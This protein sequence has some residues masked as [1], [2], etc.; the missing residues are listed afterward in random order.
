MARFST[1]RE[2]FFF[3]THPRFWFR[4][5]LRIEEMLEDPLAQ[6]HVWYDQ[7]ER[8]SLLEFPNGMCLST[9]GEDGYPQGRMV[10]MKE[11]DSEGVI[12][13]TNSNSQKGKALELT[14][15]A[16]VTFYW[17]AFQRQ[18]RF[19]GDVELLESSSSDAY[20]ASR[21]RRSQLGAWASAQSEPIES[22]EV[23]EKRVA[24][25]ETEYVHKPIPRPPYW[26]GYRLTPRMVEFWQLGLNRL[27]DRIRYVRTHDG[28]WKKER[29]SP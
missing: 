2:V 19:E 10:L 6:F 24:E 18:V 26:N 16:S 11:C 13:Y 9:V 14:P 12:F 27:H 7:I 15:R 22:R 3:L 5:H 8:S 29:L 1:P 23:L 4:R 20:F 28:C 25:L 21:P 17:G